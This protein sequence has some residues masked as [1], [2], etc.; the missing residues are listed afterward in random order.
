MESCHNRHGH[1]P[2]VKLAIEAIETYIKERRVIEPPEETTPEMAVKAGVFVC[3]KKEGELR[4]CIGTFLPTAENVAAEIIKNAI[5]AATE[6]P[7]FNCVGGGELECLDYS[8]DVLSAPEPVKSLS[9]LDPK[10][11]GV[12]V[13][14]GGRRGLLLPDLAGVDT[15]DMQVS[16]AKSKAGIGLTEPVTLHRFEVRRYE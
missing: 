15:V 10:K 11:Y 12:I 3:L 2:L 5:S 14:A 6:D 16:I 13:S 1:H 7:R 8:V 4:G 9:E